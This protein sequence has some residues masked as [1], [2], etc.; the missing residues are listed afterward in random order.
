[1]ELKFRAWDGET[2]LNRTLFDRNWYNDDNKCCKGAMPNDARTLEVMQFTGLTDMN[3]KDIYKG[4]LIT[5]GSGRIAKVVWHKRSGC[6]DCDVTNIGGHY[7]GF[8]VFDWKHNVEVIG[9]IH[10]HSHLID[11]GE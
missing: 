9:N 7:R 2:M 4:D 1:M 11:K 6:W 5:N 8:R 3:G 10:Q